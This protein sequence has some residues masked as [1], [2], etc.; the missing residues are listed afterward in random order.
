ML[1]QHLGSSA[2]HSVFPL[3][4]RL[5]LDWQKAV[6]TDRSGCYTSLEGC[7]QLGPGSETSSLNR[8]INCRQDDGTKLSDRACEGAEDVA[9]LACTGRKGYRLLRHIPALVARFA[10][11]AF[12]ETC[13][14]EDRSCP[15]LRSTR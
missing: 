13:V 12:I 3:S 2:V 5:F 11:Y 9:Y 14:A 6:G 8:S 1:L 4:E 7:C 10:A 15:V